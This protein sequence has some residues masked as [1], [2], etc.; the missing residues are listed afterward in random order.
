LLVQAQHSS[1][2]RDQAKRPGTL[3]RAGIR[4]HYLLLFLLALVPRLYLLHLFDVELSNDGFD[5]VRTLN[6]IQTQGVGAVPRDLIDRFILHPLYMILLGGLHLV[7]P[8]TV[9]FYVVGRLLSAVI[10]CLAVLVMFTFVRRSFDERAAWVAALLLAFA[11][12]F[13][14]ESV[15]ILSSTLFLLLYLGVLLSLVQGYYRAAA[16]LA[17]LAALTRYEGFVLIG[18]V[19]LCLIGRDV[20]A[21]QVER[22][23]WLALIALALAVP[24]VIIGSGWLATG[25]TTEFIGAQAMAS[26]WLRFMAAPDFARRAAFFITQYPQLFPLPVIWLGG[27]GLV[28]ALLW[29]RIRVT[30]L[31]LLTS[32]LYLAF[33]ETLVWFNY[34][35]LEVRFLM[36]P[37]LPLLVFAGV[38]LSGVRKWLAHLR[39]ST[40]WR[41][42]GDVALL[43]VLTGLLF[44][45]Y[46]Q[47]EEGMRF[48]YVMHSTQKQVAAELAHFVP[49]AAPTNVLIYGGISGALDM[50]ARQRGL[51]LTFFYFRY[52]PDGQGE[53]YVSDHAVQFIVYPVGNAFATAKYPY[54]SQLQAQ[55]RNGVTYRPLVQFTTLPDKQVYIIWSVSL[56]TNTNN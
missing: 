2:V 26:I 48:I 35:T 42:I 44:M 46:R 14:W 51:Q 17:A 30:G 28:V 54:L 20:R 18:L 47:G 40:I 19:A 1:Q 34:T 45:S 24:L 32:G 7:T 25:N 16:L 49:A 22:A 23:D 33:F 8:S 12:S 43:I 21:R 11:P 55:Q 27:A 56:A 4:Q 50:Y 3:V 13:L 9:D 6:I 38:S 36:Y 39:D 41:A 15:A 53:Q 5:A 31:L 37:G 52:A 29:R 10:G